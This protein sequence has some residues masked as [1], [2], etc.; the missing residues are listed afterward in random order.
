[1]VWRKSRRC[2]VKKLLG[3]TTSREFREIFIEARGAFGKPIKFVEGQKRHESDPFRQRKGQMSV[4][5]TGATI[6]VDTSLETPYFETVAAHELCHLLLEHDGFPKAVW[7]NTVSPVRVET[8]R[9]ANALMVNAL[10][11]PVVGRRL[12]ERGFPALRMISEEADIGLQRLE[13]ASALEEEGEG[14]NL[15]A[16]TYLNIKLTLDD[17]RVDRYAALLQQKA[18]STYRWGE[19]FAKI[20]LGSGY[21]TPDGN[22]K[23]VVEIFERLQLC[24]VGLE[25]RGR[26]HAPRW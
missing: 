4:D 14:F 22:W 3:R 5:A 21:E 13:E 8:N 25:A 23:A 1:M 2:P 24:H 9:M 12:V 20:A 19:E 7:N 17:Q 26:R 6:W 11:D 10:A 18:P 15:G 16:F